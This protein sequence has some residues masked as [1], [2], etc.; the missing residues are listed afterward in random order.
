LAALG[1]VGEAGLVG[2]WEWPTAAA[3]H[4]PKSN[5]PTPSAVLLSRFTKWLLAQ[6]RA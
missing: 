5:M 3:P 2:S 6:T 4:H 1:A